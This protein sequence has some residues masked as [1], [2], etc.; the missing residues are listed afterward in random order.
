MISLIHVGKPKALHIMALAM[1]P[2]ALEA[3]WWYSRIGDGLSRVAGGQASRWIVAHQGASDIR[4]IGT[5]NYVPQQTG[6]YA[7]WLL[8]QESELAHEFLQTLPR[9]D[10]PKRI[11]RLG[12]DRYELAA[13]V[14]E[15][16]RRGGFDLGTFPT[17]QRRAIADKFIKADDE[18]RDLDRHR[19]LLKIADRLRME[20]ESVL[21]RESES[22]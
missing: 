18:L 15:R 2:R 16:L 9:F 4:L 8:F 6:F 17:E 3:R 19:E 10:T 20:W 7:Y 12:R 5:R 1:S 11:E 21:V 22:R 13:K 14:D